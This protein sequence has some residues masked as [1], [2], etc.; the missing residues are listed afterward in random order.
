LLLREPLVKAAIETLVEV[1]S[2]EQHHEEVWSHL[3]MKRL[4][5]ARVMIVSLTWLI[6][7]LPLTLLKH[8]FLKHTN[9]LGR[10]CQRKTAVPPRAR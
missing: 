8:V 6:S 1:W 3:A 10:F 5:D 4:E 2:A 7:F 9:L